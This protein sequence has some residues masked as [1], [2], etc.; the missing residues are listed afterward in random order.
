MKRLFKSKILGLAA[1]A[2]GLTLLVGC[3]DDDTFSPASRDPGADDVE[4]SESVKSSSSRE[5]S[6]D[7]KS[8][9]SSVI[10]ASSENSRSSSS[11]SGGSVAKSLFGVD[12]RGDFLNPNIEYGTMWDSRN[13]KTYKTVKVDGVTWMA[14]NLNFVDTEN[15]PLH[16]EYT[17][18]YDDNEQNCELLGRLYERAAALNDSGCVF[19]GTC[20]IGAGAVQ[21]VCPN[22]WHIPTEWETQAL[23]D[24]ADRAAKVLMS[25]KGWSGPGFVTG[26]DLYGLSF[27]GAGYWA[28]VY[29]EY[30]NLAESGFMWVGAA[31]AYQ[32]YL[33]IR[34]EDGDAFIHSYSTAEVFLPVRCVKGDAALVSSSSRAPQ[35]SSSSV[36]SSSSSISR[37]RPASSSGAEFPLPD[38]KDDIFN[39]NIS[40]GIMTDPRDGK[41]YRTVNV[42]GDIWMAENLNFYDTLNYP[43]LKDYAFCYNYQEKYCDMMGRLYERAAAMNDEQCSFDGDCSLGLDKFQGICPDGW[44]IPTMSEAD[45]LI[46][47]VQSDA[48]GIRSAVGWAKNYPQGTDDF[49]LSFVG[50]GESSEWKF[51]SIGE[52]ASVWV[53][54]GVKPQYFLLV[55]PTPDDVI[56]HHISE[57]A[58]Y[59]SVRCVSDVPGPK[60]S[61]SS[62]S[63]SS[64]SLSSESS[65]SESSAGESSSS[66]SSS[67]ESA[68]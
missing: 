30:R 19:R 49:G 53:Y 48:S 39:P 35:S 12:S 25:S 65:S 22:G 21:G 20:G 17:R 62:E 42:D 55:R 8:S 18:C 68:A 47:F 34:A 10:P 24:L 14:E 38:S 57:Y 46:S 27:V 37:P 67:S 9:S 16:K 6:D 23:V 56:I 26:E 5:S 7:E 4:S 59:K 54:S 60:S 3:S 45:H 2:F 1:L 13:N 33:L 64:E 41:E 52:Y 15:Y 43:I 31:G 36:S 11:L 29:E 40:Y 63:S 28:G 32:K 66:E 51:K 50:S 61:S 58:M 44:H